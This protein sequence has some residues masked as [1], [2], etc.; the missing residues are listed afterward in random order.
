MNSKQIV[1]QR[2]VIVFRR[3]T[4]SPVGPATEAASGRRILTPHRMNKGSIQFSSHRH[5]ILVGLHYFWMQQG[6]SWR[7]VA[8]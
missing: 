5:R 7:L 4:I 3:L 6:W 1:A 8:G 2:I